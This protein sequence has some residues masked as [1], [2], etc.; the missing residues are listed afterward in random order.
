MNELSTLRAVIYCRKSTVSDGKSIKDQERESRSWCDTHHIPVDEVFIDDGISASRYGK[1]TR[2]AWAALK[3]RLRPGHILV[4]WEA[5]RA[6]RDLAEGAELINLCAE[7]GVPLSY[8]GK[9][10]DPSRGD[11]RFMGGLDFL[12]AARESD[13]IRERIMRGK[14]GAALDGTPHSRPPWG[15]VTVPRTTK[16]RPQWQP[17][18]KETPRIQEAARRIGAGE[19]YGSVL[20]WLQAT[21]YAPANVNALRRALINPA[22]AGKRVHQ[23]QVIG[24]AT[25]QPILTEGEQ[26]KLECHRAYSRGPQP[27]HLCSSTAICG[28]C[29]SLVR[30]K[31][32]RGKEFYTCPKGCLYQPAKELDLAVEKA[33]LKRLR[34]IVPADYATT[35][36]DS[37]ALDEAARLTADLAEWRAKAVAG[38]VSAAVYA[39]VERERLRKIRELNRSVV[40]PPLNLLDPK[41]WD[42]ADIG[43]KRDHV[44]ALLE[45]RV[46][47]GRRVSIKHV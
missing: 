36:V 41:R 5:S 33:V 9:V 8:S 43:L 1:K 23:R 4:T 32:R 29:G 47:P 24:V 13:I 45:V 35:E 17:D 19:S 28:E 3:E 10:L 20:R 21:G 2:N 11:D 31:T 44:R 42:A 30:F 7:K 39:A 38:E 16:E 15:Y 37:L 26:A 12:L 18:P 46:F 14:R 40:Q 34:N 6:T 25:W 22:L 27:R